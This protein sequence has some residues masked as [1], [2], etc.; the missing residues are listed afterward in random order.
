MFQ[1]N[2]GPE[3]ILEPS[4]VLKDAQPLKARKEAL[5]KSIPDRGRQEQGECDVAVR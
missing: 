4:R 5:G 1:K 2:S 3:R